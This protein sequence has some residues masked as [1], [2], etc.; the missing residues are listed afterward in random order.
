M[1]YPSELSFDYEGKTKVISNKNLEV[2]T[3]SQVLTYEKSKVQKGMVN[4][5]V[6]KILGK[7]K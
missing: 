5:D 2:L 6:G 7:E 1:L 4:K 3:T